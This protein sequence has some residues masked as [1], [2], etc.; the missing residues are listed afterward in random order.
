MDAPRPWSSLDF[1]LPVH[2]GHVD[3]ADVLVGLALLELDVPLLVP[4]ERDARLLVDARA[5]QVKIVDVRLV[6]DP[7]RVP[8]VPEGLD[9]LAG[10][11][12]QR[13]G[14]AGPR[15]GLEGLAARGSAL[16]GGCDHRERR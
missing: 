8:A 6:C 9:P 11:G 3:V 1:E 12:L 7:D 13:D 4:D 14:E 2:G 15:L 5:L 10:L 16:S